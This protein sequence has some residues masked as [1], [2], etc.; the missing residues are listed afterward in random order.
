LG[1][2]PFTTSRI[3]SD[4]LARIL[5]ECADG[6]MECIWGPHWLQFYG[7]ERRERRRIRK[8]KVQIE[9]FGL[10]ESTPRLI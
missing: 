4:P 8:R 6:T 5:M 2:Q 9:N 7:A 3:Q 10:M 1:G